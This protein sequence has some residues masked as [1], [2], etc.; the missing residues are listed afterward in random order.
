MKAVCKHTI[1]LLNN[2]LIFDDVVVPKFDR[3]GVM[4]ALV[5]NTHDFETSAFELARIPV[6]GTG[7]ICARE[8]VLTHKVAPNQILILEVAPKSR[9]LK[10]ENAIILKQSLNLGHEVLVVANTNVLAH[11]E[12]GNLVEL[13]PF[14]LGEVSVVEKVDLNLVANVF[15][16][17]SALSPLE[18]TR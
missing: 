4:N 3:L 10:E 17:D 12:A 8:N 13:A 9:N 6:H 11:L 5:A 7:G 2:C 14:L 18:L 1:L 15:L 16:F